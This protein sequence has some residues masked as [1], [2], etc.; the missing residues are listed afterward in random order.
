MNRTSNQLFAT[1]LQDISKS[2]SKLPANIKPNAPLVLGEGNSLAR[3]GV[4]GIS[5]SFGAALWG[6]DFALQLVVRGI[7][8]WHMHQGTNY[9]Y[10][11]WQP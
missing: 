5:N 6:L 1:R 2:I 7:G 4:G 8:R 9:R 10:Q 11:A 3:Q